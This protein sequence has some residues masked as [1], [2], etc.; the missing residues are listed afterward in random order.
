MPL[1]NDDDVDDDN[2]DDILGD[3]SSTKLTPS[4]FRGENLGFTGVCVKLRNSKLISI[5]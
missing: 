2:D 3:D 5:P 4:Y 1:L